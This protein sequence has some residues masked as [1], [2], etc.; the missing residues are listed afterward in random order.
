VCGCHSVWL[1]KF[2]PLTQCVCL[3]QCVGLSV[4]VFPSQGGCLSHCV[5]LLEESCR[6]RFIFS[7]Y[8]RS[9]SVARG[10]M[11]LLCALQLSTLLCSQP[12]ACMCVCVCVFRERKR[13]EKMGRKMRKM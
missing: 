13:G 2:V 7:S 6:T 5:C 3:S 12:V 10:Q 11:Q 9:F 1:T 8:H 4:R